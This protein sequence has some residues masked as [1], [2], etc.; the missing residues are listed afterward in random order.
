MNRRMAA[1]VSTRSA[2]PL[3][4][5]VT[6]PGLFTELRENIDAG[7]SYSIRNASISASNAA[8]SSRST[9]RSGEHRRAP[10]RNGRGGGGDSSAERTRVT[11]RSPGCRP[12]RRSKTKRGSLTTRRPKRVG[13]SWCSARYDSICWSSI[14][15]PA[16]LVDFKRR[17]TGGEIATHV[18]FG[19]VGRFTYA[20]D[21]NAIRVARVHG[22]ERVAFRRNA[23]CLLGRAAINGAH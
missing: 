18:V 6:R 22:G 21:G 5:A 7:I 10:N 13:G 3:R 8:V 4:R 1:R 15:P 19:A 20:L 23:D 2:R 16:L 17:R 11:L 14:P 9:V 12:A